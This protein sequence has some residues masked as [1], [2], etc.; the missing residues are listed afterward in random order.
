MNRRQFLVASGLAAVA[1]LGGCIQN[2]PDG[3]SGTGRDDTP[4]DPRQFQVDSQNRG[5]VDATVP[6]ATEVRWHRRLPPIDGGL[7][8]VDDR[9]VV[10]ARSEVIALD[11]GDGTEQWNRRVGLDLSAPPALTTDTA[12][13]TAWNGGP[14]EERGLA[15]LA[16]DDGTEQWRAIPDVDVSV[17]PTVADGTV[18][19]G[20]SLHSSEVVAIDATEGHERWRFEVGQYATTPA[21][22]DGAVFAGG[23]KEHVACAIDADTGDELWQFEADGEV[24]GGPTVVGSTVYV[25]S[26]SGHL[27]AVDAAN[28]DRRWEAEFGAGVAAS[29]AATNDRLFVPTRESI[30]ALD[31]DGERQWSIDRIGSTHPPI[32]AGENVVVADSRGVYCLDATTGETVWHRE[33]EEHAIGDAIYAGIDCAPVVAGGDVYV[34][35]HSGDIHALEAAG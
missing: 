10:A 19:V 23:G 8:I 16:L 6:A 13:V 25:G 17:A 31:T 29:I 28:G 3:G 9:L 12:Y 4:G 30:V 1:G 32:A 5:V 18:F 21:V 7:S 33:G 34:A 35:S 11:T 20:G 26:R 27:Y 14:Q 2:G 22:A 24:W 15:A